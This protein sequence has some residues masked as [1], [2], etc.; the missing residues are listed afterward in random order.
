M[1]SSAQPRDAGRYS[2]GIE[3]RGLPTPG[4]AEGPLDRPIWKQDESIVEST[5]RGET[6]RGIRSGKAWPH[7][8]Q[9]AGLPAS[10]CNQKVWNWNRRPGGAGPDIARFRTTYPMKI[11]RAS[12]EL[13]ETTTL[14]PV[15]NS[16]LFWLGNIPSCAAA[17]TTATATT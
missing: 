3:R 13:K 10:P 8:L 2:R 9:Q 14:A 5:R 4:H 12:E 17:A 1:V 6:S 7:V 15:Y 16:I 11:G